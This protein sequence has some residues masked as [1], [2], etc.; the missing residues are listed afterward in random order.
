MDS[1]M[2]ASIYYEDPKSTLKI[3]TLEDIELKDS[4]L[5]E[6]QKTNKNPLQDQ[7]VKFSTVQESLSPVDFPEPTSM[8]PFY[9]DG[10]LSKIN[11]SSEQMKRELNQINISDSGRSMICKTKS[12]E[13]M[14][15]QTYGYSS[16]LKEQMTEEAAYLQT[17]VC[18]WR[19][20]A[21]DGNCFY[22]STIFGWLEYLVMNAMDNVLTY[23]VLDLGKK[24]DANYP[25]VSRLPSS[26]RKNFTSRDKDIVILLLD[27]IIKQ[28]TDKSVS[29]KQKR[30]KSAYST[31]VKAFNFSRA[32][33][34]VMILYLRFLLYEFILEN[35][36]KIFSK[37][38]PVLLG[39]LLPGQYETERGDFLFDKYFCEDLLRFYTC[40]EKL[41]VYL[42]PFVLKINI[43]V[44]CYDFGTDCD[45][46]TK[47]FKC[48]LPHKDTIMV[49]YR[50]AH[51]DICY[52]D[53][54]IMKY[55]D[56]ITMFNEEFAY[57]QVINQKE[58]QNLLRKILPNV[59]EGSKV[60][61]RVKKEE[62]IKKE[63]MKPQEENDINAKL[64]EMKDKIN[65]I[66]RCVMCIK[67]ITT[68]QEGK[69]NKLPCGCEM[70]FCSD[71]CMKQFTERLNE[72]V[73][74]GII[75]KCNAFVCP[76]CNT[77]IRK[78]SLLELV[79]SFDEQYKGTTQTKFLLRDVLTET[80]QTT[81]MNCLSAVT[82]NAKEVECKAKTVGY[83]MGS[84]KFKHY[85]CENCRKNQVSNCSICDMYHFRVAKM[86]K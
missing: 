21:G 50:K 8:T 24:F 58:V 36:N 78:H 34:T 33:D 61:N 18:R 4:S 46:Q 69:N 49:M 73:S 48:Y 70:L 68:A 56:Y 15:E 25:Y 27:I 47:E 22:R 32:F 53:D 76:K 63:K 44:V 42:S 77:I 82:E 20:V 29:N 51:Y 28:L 1:S 52:S 12:I 64:Q 10:V 16:S 39:N 83:I 85:L 62:A 19:R 43:K 37:D 26:I 71:E 7:P 3:S 9:Y 66:P 60:F 84:K 6:E 67:M 79:E 35:E 80:F 86:S 55:I 59:E 57:L 31:L 65:N 81:C 41:A 2:T 30:I 74:K 14:V 38:F 11:L 75:D 17:I 13:E 5:Q 23:V 45:I 40:A 72:V 54:Y